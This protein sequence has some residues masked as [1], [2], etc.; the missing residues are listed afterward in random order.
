MKRHP[1]LI[2]LAT[3]QMNSPSEVVTKRTAAGRCW[4]AGSRIEIRVWSYKKTFRIIVKSSLRGK[5][6]K[7]LTYGC[8]AA[9][10]E[11]HWQLEASFS[12]SDK[13]GRGK[14]SD[15]RAS[16]DKSTATWAACKLDIRE[17]STSSVGR[18]SC[19]QQL[20]SSSDIR[21]KCSLF[22]PGSWGREWEKWDTFWWLLLASSCISRAAPAGL[23]SSSCSRSS[24][25]SQL[26][27]VRPESQTRRN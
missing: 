14:C 10:L 15:G 25:V 27:L 3:I 19:A 6:V 4:S 26:S 2:S 7:I 22:P 11:T 8:S 5:S 13:T 18:F 23:H 17:C 16:N 20:S 1:I 24:F 9:E 21:Q 12:W